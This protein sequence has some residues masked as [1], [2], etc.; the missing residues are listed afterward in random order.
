MRRE[1]PRYEINYWKVMLS[2]V[3]DKGSFVWRYEYAA[4]EMKMRSELILWKDYLNSR[5]NNEY[6]S[7]FLFAWRGQL[8]GHYSWQRIV[9]SN[10]DDPEK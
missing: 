6:S 10:S 4:M 1:T 9:N 3:D 8:L 7:G 5:N 2:L